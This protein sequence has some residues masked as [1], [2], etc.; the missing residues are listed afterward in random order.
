MLIRI[1]MDGD[2]SHESLA[3]IVPIIWMQQKR[4]YEGKYNTNNRFLN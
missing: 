3:C 4:K 2:I 1:I